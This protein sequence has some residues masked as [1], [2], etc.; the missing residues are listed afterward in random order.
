MTLLGSGHSNK[1]ILYVIADVK[2]Y[3]HSV[4]FLMQP[5]IMWYFIHHRLRQDNEELWGAYCE[6]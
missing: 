4:A 3:L 5:N 2:L 6:D 1:N